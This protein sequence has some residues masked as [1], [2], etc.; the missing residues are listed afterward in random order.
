MTTMTASD[1]AL[2]RLGTR[3][4]LAAR[5]F[6]HRV[7]KPAVRWIAYSRTVRSL[8]ETDEHLLRDMGISRHRIGGYVDDMIAADPSVS[9]AIAAHRPALY[10]FGNDNVQRSAGRDYLDAA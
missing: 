9:A 1:R 5:W 3:L 6:S 8:R 7:W 10:R 4:R 2:R